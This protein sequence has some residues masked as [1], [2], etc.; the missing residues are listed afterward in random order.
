LGGADA[1]T[2]A[3]DLLAAG[4]VVNAVTPSALRLAPSLLISEEEIDHGVALL[5]QILASHSGAT[6]PT[7][8]TAPSVPNDTSV[9][10]DAT[11]EAFPTEE[12]K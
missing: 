3:A 4:V 2:V 9:P 1:R 11:A 8:A 7:D 6:V 12:T 5:A 10:T